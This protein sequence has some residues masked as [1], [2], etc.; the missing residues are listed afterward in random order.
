MTT[1]EEKRA[2]RARE[3]EKRE[4]NRDRHSIRRETAAGAVKPAV[5]PP[6]RI[7]RRLFG[8]VCKGSVRFQYSIMARGSKSDHP[9]QPLIR[10][11][12]YA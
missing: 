1:T 11:V 12:R 5:E 7:I 4:E 6:N 10:A 3:K 8:V 2:K 9:V